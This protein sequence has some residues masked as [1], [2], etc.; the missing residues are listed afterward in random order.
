MNRQD[1]KKLILT[2]YPILYLTKE[3]VTN[4]LWVIKDFFSFAHLPEVREMLWL[5]L[6]TNVTGSFP[7]GEALNP[8]DRLYILLLYEQLLRLVEAAHLLNEKDKSL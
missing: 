1:T 7:Q 6:K 5:S 3:E 4:P 2:D 8:R